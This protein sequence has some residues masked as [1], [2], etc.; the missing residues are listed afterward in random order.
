MLIQRHH[1]KGFHVIATARS[2]TALASLA[3]QGISSVPLDVTNDS[4]IIECRRKVAGITG[5]RLD[6][7]VNN[8]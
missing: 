5:G 7:L 8:A 2:S 3:K 4:S 1:E 6:I